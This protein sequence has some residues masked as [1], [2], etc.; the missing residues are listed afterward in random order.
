MSQ[1]EKALTDL[2]AACDFI[3]ET[4][5]HSFK[6]C[7]SGHVGGGFDPDHCCKIGRLVAALAEYRKP[8]ICLTCKGTRRHVCTFD[9][10]EECEQRGGPCY[11]C[12]GTGKET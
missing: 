2:L 6:I 4:T 9:C 5:A 1:N 11:G 7:R 10:R 3:V 12:D 8:K